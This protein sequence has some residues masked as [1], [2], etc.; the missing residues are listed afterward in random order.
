MGRQ[1]GV[2]SLSSLSRGH[3]VYSLS[4]VKQRGHESQAPTQQFGMVRWHWLLHCAVS[5]LP[6]PP[7][8]CTL[9]ISAACESRDLARLSVTS[10]RAV[11]CSPEKTLFS[12]S[13]SLSDVTVKKKKQK[14]L[15]AESL[16][17][18]EQI[19]LTLILIHGL[20]WFN[21]AAGCSSIVCNR[22]QL[23]HSLTQVSLE[24]S[25]LSP[26]CLDS[27]TDFS[28]LSYPSAQLWG[29]PPAKFSLSSSAVFLFLCRWSSLLWETISSTGTTLWARMSPSYWRSDRP[30][31]MP[32]SSSPRGTRPAHAYCERHVTP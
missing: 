16:L 7:W 5:V 21:H 18:Q 12:L 8:E 26:W 22:L 15:M 14:R 27:T 20:T 10:C 19:M 3:S 17:T 31:R 23:N 13:L 1:P 2:C 9:I 6:S 25:N 32:S 28:Y 24:H 29:C 4:T 11:S 30:C